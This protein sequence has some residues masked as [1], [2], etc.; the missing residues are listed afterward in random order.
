M[1]PSIAEL[2]ETAWWM[3]AIFGAAALVYNVAWYG[4]LIARIH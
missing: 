3:L 1:R 2:R 4:G